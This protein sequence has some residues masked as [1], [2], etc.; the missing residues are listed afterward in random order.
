MK[1]LTAWF[2]C[3][4]FSAKRVALSGS[5]KRSAGVSLSSRDAERW[6]K[7]V[8]D[9]TKWISAGTDD[10]DRVGAFFRQGSTGAGPEWR[11]PVFVPDSS[12]VPPSNQ[13]HCRAFS[14]S[15]FFDHVEF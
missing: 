7:P 6:K 2:F 15:Q 3:F 9:R 1:W 11:D 13:K 10:P 14:V 8:K 12:T 4:S 5:G